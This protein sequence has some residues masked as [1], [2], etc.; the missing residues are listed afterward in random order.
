MHSPVQSHP[1]RGLLVVE[2]RILWLPQ[3]VYERILCHC[4]FTRACSSF[5]MP[6]STA[7]RAFCHR[8][9][10]AAILDGVAPPSFKSA[11]VVAACA[12]ILATRR[13][14]IRRMRDPSNTGPRPA[15]RF[16]MS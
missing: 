3:L 10:A 13:Q 9:M 12:A 8:A 2:R 6:S 16:A 5:K 4:P 14:L 11:I 1:Q 7:S 15:I